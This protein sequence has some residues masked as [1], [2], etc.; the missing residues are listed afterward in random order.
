MKEATKAYQALALLSG[1]LDSP[2]DV[3]I[4]IGQGIAVAS[5]HFT[6]PFHNCTSRRAGRRQRAVKVAQEFGLPQ[7]TS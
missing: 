6:R 2:L 7:R 1:D 3:K 5:V 4:M